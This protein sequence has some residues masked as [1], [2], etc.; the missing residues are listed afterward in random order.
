MRSADTSL[1]RAA[2][3]AIFTGGNRA[4]LLRG[5]DALFPAMV[6]AI[7]SARHEVWLA[8]YIYT[9]EGRVKAIT[10]ALADAARRGVR[11]KLVLDGFGCRIDLPRLQAELC[12]AGAEIEVFRRID[13]WWNWLQ[14]GQ[15]RR[16]HQKICVVDGEVAF[17]GGV[18]LLDDRYDQVHGWT[19]TPRLDFAVR[20]VGP[21]V[22]PIEQAVRALFTRAHL[23][24]NFRHEIA[25]LARSAEP[26]AR[27]RRMMRRLRMSPTGADAT[28]AALAPVRAA[29]VLRDNLR[30]R[31]AIE[32]AYID[33]IRNARERVDLVS[34]YFYPGRAFRRVL[35]QAARRGVQVRLLM[36]GKVD[37][38]IA[39]LAARALYDEMLADGVRI[40]E[41]TPAF[42]HAKVALVDSD[43]ATVGSS[44]IDPLSLLLN[45]EAN[46]M[47]RDADFNRSLA[48]EFD[49]AV[50]VSQE[51]DARH[52]VHPTGVR[53]SVRRWWV[54]WCA[55]VYLKIAGA[56][57]RY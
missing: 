22:V 56:T 48:H 19:D 26:V 40:F 39:A 3:R 15:L 34:P 52:Q 17:V 57:G 42:L 6:D 18:N 43:W 24:S 14:P 31:R 28:G 29:F 35:R 7:A 38:R 12:P 32:R 47:V 11:V 41:Y 55:H 36:Q 54:A 4:T 45:L 5:G 20:V 53:A 49:T 13:R 30:R 16:L 37:Y 8:T 1:T 2:V 23:G 21:V 25:S 46:V 51:I 50:A 27:A 33:A 44:N 9:N 10:Q